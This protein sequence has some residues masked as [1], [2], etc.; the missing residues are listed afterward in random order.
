M[1]KLFCLLMAST[2][3]SGLAGLGMAHAA[4]NFAPP[5]PD[6]AAQAP[7]ILAQAATTPPEDNTRTRQQQQNK[8]QRQQPRKDTQKP[9]ATRSPPPPP[10]A[11]RPSP[12]PPPAARDRSNN[13]PAN[14]N[15]QPATGRNQDRGANRNATTPASPPPPPV[16]T[17]RTGQNRD[18]NTNN[19]GGNNNGRDT[20]THRNSGNNRGGDVNRNNATT[21]AAGT[22]KPV[23]E[24]PRSTTPNNATNQRGPN[25][26]A[27]TPSTNLTPSTDKTKP[28][29]SGGAGRG[30]A[31]QTS[32]GQPVRSVDQ[33]RSERKE[34]KEGGR[35]V[36]REPDRTI[37][38]EGNN[39]TIIRHDENNRFRLGAQNV[40]IERRGNDNVTTIVR[41][42]GERIVTVVDRNGF[43]LRRSRILPNGREIIIINQRPRVGTFFVVL[44]PPRILIPQDR[45]IVGY[46][47][48]PP[49]LLYATLMA[50]PVD[51][52][53]RPYSLEEIR[54]SAPVRDRM[55]RID[56]DDIT[57]DTGSW[58]LAPE[59]IDK[60]APIADG[61]KRAIEANPKVVF[62]IE[63]HTDAVGDENDNLSLSDRRAES[64]AVALTEQFQVAAENLTTQGYGEQQLKVPT[65]GPEEANRRVTVRNIAPLLA[66]NAGG[67]PPQG[68]PGAPSEPVPQ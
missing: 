51:V 3:L 24:N 67:Q 44:P 8:D 39:K 47:G 36:I 58:D 30:I 25:T 53:E 68:D 6:E 11:N 55:P 23:V 32:Q 43:L 12:P 7:I 5:R 49:A 26:G 15:N 46:R 13:A 18:G 16:T 40:R 37:I 61:M 56:L 31:V 59:Q 41:P 64:V 20:N 28:I 66:G 29:Q 4:N 21:P 42:G 9:D 19:R 45:Y 1:K 52:I 48:A 62:L 38:R 10:A 54:Y 63:G 14:S 22:D 34:T 33:L 2:V 65:N 17:P 35:T 50:P 60:L 57:F 27:P